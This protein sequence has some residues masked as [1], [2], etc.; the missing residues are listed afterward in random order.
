[1]FDMDGK[2]V[3]PQV[4]QAVMEKYKQPI[5]TLDM[6]R[7]AVMG[8]FGVPVTQVRAYIEADDAQRKVMSN[9][10]A[11]IPMDTLKNDE[12]LDWVSAGVSYGIAAW[13]EKKV[14]N[15]NAKAPHYA[16][17]ADGRAKYTIVKKVIDI[18]QKAG[19]QHFDLITSLK[20]MPK[21]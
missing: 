5:T 14:A 11:G 18:C 9:G 8:T 20:A 19:I 16:I 2:D 15:P 21:S 13:N 10:S 17:K 6:S 4:L 7:F 3:R 1:F 12:L